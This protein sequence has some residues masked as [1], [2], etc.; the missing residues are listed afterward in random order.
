MSNIIK[1]IAARAK[2]IRKAK[3]SIKWQAA[4][5]QASKELKGKPGN[6]AKKIGAAAKKKTAKK[7]AVKKTSY[8]QTGSSNRKR[9]EERRAMPPGKRVV[10]TAN[11]SH[12]YY[13]RRKNRSDAPGSLSGAGMS[14]DHAIQRVVMKRRLRAKGFSLD[15]NILDADLQ[16]AYVKLTG[17]KV[18]AISK[19]RAKLKKGIA[20]NEIIASL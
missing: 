11:G 13:E 9:D 4:I 12:V 10:K 8:R 17:R 7:K 20:I 14:Q 3:P 5:K 6:T 1:K 16:K 18:P 2:Q 19:I 15:N